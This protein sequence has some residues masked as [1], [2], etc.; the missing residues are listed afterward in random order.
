VTYTPSY[1]K[2]FLDF[3]VE[4]YQPIS[5]CEHCTYRALCNSLN[6]KATIYGHEKAYRL[7]SKE[8]IDIRQGITAALKGMY[9]AVTTD[10]WTANNNVNYTTCTV[11]FIDKKT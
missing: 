9:F 4:T 10:A 7:I 3:V 1:E 2:C 8:V 11:H 5:I 6:I